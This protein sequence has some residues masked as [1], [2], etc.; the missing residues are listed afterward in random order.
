ME[1]PTLSAARGKRGLLMLTA[2]TLLTTLSVSSLAGSFDDT[3][4]FVP[5]PSAIDFVD[6]GEG[7]DPATDRYVPSDAP[8]ECLLESFD[9]VEDPGALY[10]THTVQ[11]NVDL[12]KGCA[13]RFIVKVPPCPSGKSMSLV[14]WR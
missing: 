10:G 7:F 13:E 1:R 9:V 3:G 11:V 2:A 5:D 6:F 14:L 4:R 12:Q 8:Q